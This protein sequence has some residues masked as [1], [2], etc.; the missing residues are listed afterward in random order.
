MID[1][2]LRDSGFILDFGFPSWRTHH[3]PKDV[4][5]FWL[6]S[7][8]D[9]NIMF[10]DV[11]IHSGDW[12]H[13]DRDGMVRIPCEHLDGIIAKSLEAMQKENKVREAILNGTDPQTAYLQYGK[14]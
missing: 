4:V 13:G 3:T 14:F 9:I 7:G 1:G 10:D 5:G 12:L 11:L 2:A 8:V 6:P